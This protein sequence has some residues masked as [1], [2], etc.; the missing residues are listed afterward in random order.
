MLERYTCQTENA[1][2]RAYLAVTHM[3]TQNIVKAAVLNPCVTLETTQM[4]TQNK[5]STKQHGHCAY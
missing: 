2:A 1:Q 3:D 4:L 5:A